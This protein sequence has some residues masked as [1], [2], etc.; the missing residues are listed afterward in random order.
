MRI[1]KAEINNFRS[2]EKTVLSLDNFNVFVGQ[3]NHGKTNFFEAINWFFNGYARETK[4]NLIFSEANEIADI[5]VELT[6]SGLQDAISDMTNEAKKTAF[7]NMFPETDEITIRRTT[8]YDD[9]KKRELFNPNNNEWTNLMGADGTWNDLLPHIEYVST[10]I[11]LDDIGGY[12]S[13]SPIAEML[14]GVL[15]SIVESDEKYLELKKSF[16]D[17]FGGTSE[18]R[19]QLD[20]LGGKVQ[21]FLKKQFPDDAQVKFNVE[22]PEFGDML[23]KFSTEVND[24]VPTTIEEKGDGMQRAVMLSII[25]AYA[26]YR[27]ENDIEKRFIFLID[28]AE[29]HLHPSAQ[30]ALKS[31]LLDIS[32]N[33]DQVL[34]NTH[35]S[36]L[37]TDDVGGQKIFK[38]EK[39]NKRTSIDSVKTTNEKMSVIFDLLGGSPMDLLF[40]NNIGVV[41]GSSDSTFLSHCIQLLQ[42]ENHNIKHIVF[43]YSSG[44]SR[45][46]A[47]TVGIDEMLKTASY[48][49]IYKNKLCV[50]LD[51]DVD[52]GIVNAIRLFLGDTDKSRVVKLANPGIEYYYPQDLLREVCVIEKNSDLKP[53]I[54]NYSSQANSSED[55]KGEL[56][57]FNGTKND[58]AKLICSR[59]NDISQLDEE[60]IVWLKVVLAKSY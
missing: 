37:V 57:S 21:V 17:L 45:T 42:V 47:A 46:Y 25:Q 38:V 34:V 30:R 31:A 54:V 27:K 39:I 60:L 53:L 51:G 10:R 40:P 5:S 24:G 36:V 48:I 59:L 26:D 58:L 33:H 11:T 22:I 2:I 14:S 16:E 55:G 12:K 19:T 13:K 6:F 50:L 35:S 1:V 49:P 56:G 41:D 43:H 4:N 52:N 32:R 18:V 15:T 20:N 9:G 3:N 28:E 29:L 23:K 7:K 8:E 44:D